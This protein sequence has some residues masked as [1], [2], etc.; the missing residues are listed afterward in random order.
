MTGWRTIEL[1]T[2]GTFGQAK[3]IIFAIEKH[4]TFGTKTPITEIFGGCFDNIVMP[5]FLPILAQI[6]V[7]FSITPASVHY[8]VD[9]II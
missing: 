8:I 3:M 4:D 9:L 7:C 1:K 6:N 2:F 5:F